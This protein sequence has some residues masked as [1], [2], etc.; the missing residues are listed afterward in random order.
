ME[1]NSRCF[2]YNLYKLK[3]YVNKYYDKEHINEILVIM[4]NNA[5]NNYPNI[6]WLNVKKDFFINLGKDDIEKTMIYT[7]LVDKLGSKFMNIIDIAI[8]DIISTLL[9][10]SISPYNLVNYTKVFISDKIYS[11]TSYAYTNHLIKPRHIYRVILDNFKLDNNI[12]YDDIIKLINSFVLEH[13]I[14]IFHGNYYFFN[15]YQCLKKLISLNYYP[16]DTSSL[17]LIPLFNTIEDEQIKRQIALDF[18]YIENS[19]LP[20]MDKIKECI[21]ISTHYGYD[22]PLAKKRET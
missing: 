22:L 13:K 15:I 17:E 3:S 2:D 11:I 4:F 5:I 7:I 12:N 18:A 14:K 9:N 6:N 10:Y 20:L 1:R 8:D 21:N 16:Y 19:D